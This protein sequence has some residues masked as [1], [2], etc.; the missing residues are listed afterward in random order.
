MVRTDFV[1]N[2]SSSSFM[3]L[4]P[5][6][7]SEHIDKKFL[8]IISNLPTGHSY[9]NGYISFDFKDSSEDTKEVTSLMEKINSDPRYKIESYSSDGDPT[10]FNLE[11]PIT[12]REGEH[13]EI[14]QLFKHSRSVIINFG[15][16]DCGEKTGLMASILTMLLMNYNIKVDS[17]DNDIDDIKEFVDDIK[18]IDIDVKK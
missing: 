12:L 17:E 4:N 15:L 5:D 7:V 6:V 11:N 10:G 9:G 3:I 18:R 1:S 16:D 2:S 8:T 13:P 14:I